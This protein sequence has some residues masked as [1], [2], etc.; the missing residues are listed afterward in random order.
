V[1]D[2]SETFA[3]LVRLKRQFYDLNEQHAQWCMTLPP[4]LEMSEDQRGRMRQTQVQM[5]DLAAQIHGHRAFEGLDQMRR[6]ELDR[7]ASKAARAE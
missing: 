1:T 4:A 2:N 7:E 3:D 6:Y 5:T